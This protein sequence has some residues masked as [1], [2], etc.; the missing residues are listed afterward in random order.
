[1]RRFLLTG[2]F[3]TVLLLP[4]IGYATT[5]TWK[6]QTTP[7]AA[8][9]F[10]VYAIN[11]SKA[12]AVGNNTLAKTINRVTWTDTSPSS[13][14]TYNSAFVV[15]SDAYV[16]GTDASN[17]VII[18]STNEGNSWSGASAVVGSASFTDLFFIGTYGW[19]INTS[20]PRVYKTV[21]SGDNWLAA[22]TGL[23]NIPYNA[24]Y[25]TS[26]SEGWVAGNGG[27]IYKTTNGGG[28]WTVQ[29]SGTANNLNDIFF[30]DANTGWAVGDTGTI[31]KTTDGGTTWA[32]QTSGTVNNLNSVSFGTASVGWAVGDSG[33]IIKSSDGGSSWAAQASG[34]VANLNGV[35]FID[36]YNGWTVGN[37]VILRHYT[38]TISS[39]TRTHPAAGEVTWESQGA[40]RAITI[41]GANF[42]TGAAVTFEG[43]TISTLYASVESSAKIT[44]TIWVPLAETVGL[45]NLKM[46]N[47]DTSTDTLSNGF[48]IRAAGTSPTFT[49]WEVGYTSSDASVAIYDLPTRITVEV[50]D[51]GGLTRGSIKFVAYLSSAGSYAPEYYYLF[52]G[53]TIG[54]ETLATNGATI[55]KARATATLRYFYKSGESTG[56]KYYIQDLINGK[57]KARPLYFYVENSATYPSYLLYDSEVYYDSTKI[58]PGATVVSTPLLPEAAVSNVISTANPA[59][60]LQIEVDAATAASVTTDGAIL[61]F[62]GANGIVANH[63]VVFRRVNSGLTA[64]G[65]RAS[66][67]GNEIVKVTTTIGNVASG[68]YKVNLMTADR[69]TRFGT[70]KVVVQPWR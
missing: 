29:T 35:S 44:A 18:Y 2:I 66:A 69:K 17:G 46:T 57:A 55:T 56:T 60:T 23:A 58:P 28:S 42:Q 50:E 31:L 4:S 10:A 3:I 40:L 14:Y 32:T 41:N 24:V 48:E 43:S 34:T 16:V 39:V 8:E 27:N 62:S 63:N 61:L 1:M 64:S 20:S 38:A 12:L 11:G 26:T 5:V 68:I 54:F 59:F 52:S 37:N 49:T 19:V 13:I 25:F 67:A 53:D 65:I 36:A 45:K 7:T 47:T 6:A 9:L 22:A 70:G 33:T 15:S 51:T 30:M 21:D